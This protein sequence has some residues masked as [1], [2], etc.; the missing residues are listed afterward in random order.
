LGEYG[1]RRENQKILYYQSEFSYN[2][3][4]KKECRFYTVVN[5]NH[6]VCNTN[7]KCIQWEDIYEGLKGNRVTLDL[8]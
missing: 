5:L 2:T 8:Q 7:Y 6:V 1:F 3:I 4:G